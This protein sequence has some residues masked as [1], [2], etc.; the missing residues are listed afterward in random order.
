MTIWVRGDQVRHISRQVVGAARGTV[1][2][3]FEDLDHQPCAAVQWADGD[4]VVIRTKWLDSTCP[5]L[6]EGV[7]S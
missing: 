5:K 6:I 2:A 3:S 4:L 1:L 7:R